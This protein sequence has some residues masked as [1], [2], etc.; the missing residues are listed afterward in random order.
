MV[1]RRTLAILALS[2]VAATPTLPAAAQAQP[3]CGDTI[4]QDTTLTADLS[5]CSGFAAVIVTGDTTLDLGG[6]TV[7]GDANVGIIAGQGTLTIR[8]GT[9]SGFLSGVAIAK[10]GN[11]YITRITAVGNDVGFQV[12]H[13]TALFD[14]DVASHNRGDGFNAVSSPGTSVAATFLHNRADRNGGLGIDAPGQ[15]DAGKNHAHKNGDPRQC[16]GVRC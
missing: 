13:A 2:L 15:T 7:S 12:A 16:V 6:H 1:M 9:V 11:A 5:G 4:T 3:S 14:R 10:G 8:D